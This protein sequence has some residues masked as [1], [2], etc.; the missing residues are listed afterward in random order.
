MITVTSYDGK[1][2]RIPEEKREE[3]ERRQRLIKQYIKQGK[4]KA[5]I[6]EILKNEQ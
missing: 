1:L 3:Y 6:R 5:E 2:V 4:T